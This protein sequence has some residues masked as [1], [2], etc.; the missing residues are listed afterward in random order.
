MAK[1]KHKTEKKE[2]K[3]TRQGRISQ[4]IGAV[5]DVQFDPG[6]QPDPAAQAAPAASKKA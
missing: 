6:D 3:A 2:K 5:T 4:V 1:T